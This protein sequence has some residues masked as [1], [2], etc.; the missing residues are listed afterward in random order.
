M[1]KLHRTGCLV[2]GAELAYQ[3]GHNDLECFLCHRTVPS[4]VKCVEGHFVCDRCHSLSGNDFVEEVCL[5][6]TSKDPMELVGVLMN[7]TKVPM[8]GPEHHFIV[9]AALLTAYYNIMGDSEQKRRKV[10]E[11]RA[12]SSNILGGFCGYYGDCGAAVGTGIFLSLITD[13][14]PLSTRDWRLSNMVT[15]KSLLSVAIHGGP[16]C[17]KRNTWISITEAVNFLEENLQ[18]TISAEKDI[19]CNYSAL[20]KECLKENCLYYSKRDVS[21]E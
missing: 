15:A 4:T 12:R 18:M 13:S 14:T 21:A 16:R 20:N 1:S 9:P 5:N 10:K 11:A 8:H 2:C 17:C 19:K 7:S 3:T 6:S